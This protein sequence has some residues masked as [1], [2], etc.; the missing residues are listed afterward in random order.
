MPIN[1]IEAKLVNIR[2]HAIESNQSISIDRDDIKAFVLDEKEIIFKC[3]N[4][5]T[6][7]T[8]I[9]N[10]YLTSAVNLHKIKPETFFNCFSSQEQV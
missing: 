10:S 6:Q 9:I 4:S 8:K 2:K 5:V 1:W 3:T 7:N